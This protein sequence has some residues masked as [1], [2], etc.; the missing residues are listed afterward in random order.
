MTASA[1]PG[2][3]TGEDL[4]A[5]AARLLAAEGPAAR[6]AVLRRVL[7]VAPHLRSLVLR[8]GPGGRVLASARVGEEASSSAPPMPRP[9]ADGEWALDVPVRQGPT[10]HGVLTATSSQPFNGADAGML[11]AV[12]D[13]LA[14]VAPYDVAAAAVARAVL[15][16]EADFA[17]LAADLDESLGEALVALRHTDAAHVDEALAA[18]LTVLRRLRRDLRATA[19]HDGLRQALAEL[20]APDVKV[21]ARDPRL[22]ELPPA[23]AVL[24]ERVAETLVRDAVGPVQITAD[25]DEQMVKLSVES[26]DNLIDASELERWRRRVQAMRGSLE[27]QQGIV[28]LRVPVLHL[29]EGRHDH[30]PDL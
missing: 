21:L 29:D 10:L 20:A 3:R 30:S 25:M 5:A 18:A 11:S 9:P 27:Q 14:L 19:L 2:A 7:A 6:P 17:L 22:D 8:A 24:V 4:V 1:P 15:D 16:V 23:A 13:V 26:A 12:A 28:L